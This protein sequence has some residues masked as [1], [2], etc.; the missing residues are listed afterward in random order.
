MIANNENSGIQEEIKPKT[1]TRAKEICCSIDVWG[2][3]INRVRI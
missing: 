3:L 1:L 2:I